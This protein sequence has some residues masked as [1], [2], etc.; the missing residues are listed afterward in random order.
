M[1]SN[2]VL[3]WLPTSSAS[4][5]SHRSWNPFAPSPSSYSSTMFL[6]LFHPFAPQ[7]SYCSSTT[8]LLLYHPVGLFMI[9]ATFG[10][11]GNPDLIPMQLALSMFNEFDFTDMSWSKVAFVLFS[12]ASAFSAMRRIRR[13][14]KRNVGSRPP[15]KHG[16]S[17]LNIRYARHAFFRSNGRRDGRT[18]RQTMLPGRLKKLGNW[19]ST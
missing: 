19:A 11:E 8:L 7:P 14:A 6:L 12:D 3:G 2:I 10:V 13:V 15:T 1:S 17:S 18:D 4:L 16:L 5:L 9:G